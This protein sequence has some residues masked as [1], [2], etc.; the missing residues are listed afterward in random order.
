TGGPAGPGDGAPAT[1]AS[2]RSARA[3]TSGSSGMGSAPADGPPDD[4]DALV[5]AVAMGSMRQDARPDGEPVL[6]NRARHEH[7]AR[8]VDPLEHSLVRLIVAV[9]ETE[10]HD[11]ELGLPWKLEPGDPT[12]AVVQDAREVQLL[13]EGLPER[14]HAVELEGE[15]DAEAPKVPPELGRVL[16]DVRDLVV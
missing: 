6:D 10:R 12:Q 8:R 9:D 15:P 14:R 1:A 5:D 3:W 2:S 7:P 11:R 16:G 4:V 13:V